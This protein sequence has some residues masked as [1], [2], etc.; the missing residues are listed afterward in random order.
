MPDRP[1]HRRILAH[2]RGQAVAYVAIFL[3]LGG[4]YALA[5]A[6][7]KTIHSCVVKKTG[8]LLIKARCDRGQ[9]R[10]VWNQRGPQGPQGPQGAP[11]VNAW[12]VVTGAANVLTGQGVSVTHASAGTYQ[13]T[14]TAAACANKVNSPTVT[15]LDANP[16]NGQSPG[17][18]PVA[19][20]GGS[21]NQQFTV[22]TGI[23]A[24]GA[25]T[26]TDHAFDIH[27]SC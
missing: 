7:N 23:V 5:A 10:L 20:V 8:E 2:L 3:A 4:G 21:G 11:A 13:V 19:W 16:P 1:L 17:A 25:F 12:A 14:V 22:Y 27:D 9:S 15:V 6:K 26:A 18:F 24:G